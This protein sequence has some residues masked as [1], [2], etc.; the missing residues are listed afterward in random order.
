MG[1]DKEYGCVDEKGSTKEIKTSQ[2]ELYLQLARISLSKGSEVSRAGIRLK[3][4]GKEN[5]EKRK[6]S[7]QKDT[8]G[9]TERARDRE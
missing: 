6:K 9:S 1:K 3:K 7:E 2:R 8:K 5:K 4:K